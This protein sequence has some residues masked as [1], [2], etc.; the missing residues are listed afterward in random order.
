M[1][2][3]SQSKGYQEPAFECTVQNGSILVSSYNFINKLTN[4][5]LK[6]VKLTN[7]TRYF[8]GLAKTMNE[9]AA[10]SILVNFIEPST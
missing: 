4:S 7:E 1:Y 5:P 10:A 6:N 8:Y 3:G 2:I 9:K